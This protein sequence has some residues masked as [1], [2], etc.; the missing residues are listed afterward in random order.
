VTLLILVVVLAMIGGTWLD[1][2]EA[3][4]RSRSPEWI[5][6]LAMAGMVVSCLTTL[7]LLLPMMGP[8]ADNLDAAAQPTHLPVLWPLMAFTLCALGFSVA[9]V[10]KQKTQILIFLT[11]LLLASFC[12]G[13]V[14][15]T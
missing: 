7:S 9:A 2:Q 8:S 4:R 5:S 14:L 10:R 12:L 1:W 3:E 11:G 13:F 6:G 15:A